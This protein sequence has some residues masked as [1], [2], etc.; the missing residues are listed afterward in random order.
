[1]VKVLRSKKGFT[2]VEIMIVVAI[3][4]LLAAIAVP[5]FVQ[6]RTTTRVNVILNDL[7]M[8]DSAI[9]QW[10]LASNIADGDDVDAD[11]ITAYIKGGEVPTAPDSTEYTIN[12]VG[13]VP[14]Y[15]GD[16]ELPQHA[17]D[18]GFVCA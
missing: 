4:G 16:I 15:G 11:A 2:L 5:N 17:Q 18:A 6:A 8:I 1:M 3:I 10:A 12:A 7:R 13:T 9:E 14:C